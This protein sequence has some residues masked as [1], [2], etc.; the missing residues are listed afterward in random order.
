MESIIHS[1]EFLVVAACP[2]DSFFKLLGLAGLFPTGWCQ[3]GSIRRV[4]VTCS[5]NRLMKFLGIP[6]WLMAV[7]GSSTAPA[8]TCSNPYAQR[9]CPLPLIQPFRDQTG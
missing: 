5:P 2:Y 1:Q 9:A 7:F 3:F 8:I 6:F 4:P